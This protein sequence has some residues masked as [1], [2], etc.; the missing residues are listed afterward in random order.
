MRTFD[1]FLVDLQKCETFEELLGELGFYFVLQRSNSSSW[2]IGY[3]SNGN[4]NYF[5][6]EDK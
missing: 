4:V 3:D 6:L 5:S 2:K 1:E